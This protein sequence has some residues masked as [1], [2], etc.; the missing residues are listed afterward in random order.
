MAYRKR[1]YTK[2]SYGR[3]TGRRSYKA[4]GRRRS[5]GRRGV[6]RPVSGSVGFRL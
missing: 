1:S 5:T 6:K 4:R 3:S 2:R